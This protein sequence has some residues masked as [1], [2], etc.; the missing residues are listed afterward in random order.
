MSAQNAM[1][2]HELERFL[3]AV[4]TRGPSGQRNLALLTLMADSGL[5][6]G[7]ALGISTTDLVREHGGRVVTH[8]Q[9]QGKGSKPARVPISARTAAR[10]DTWLEARADLGVGNGHVFCTISTGTR[11]A[12]FAQ[13]G[14][15]LVPGK[16][17]D[18]RYVRDL[19]GR[20]ALKA[21]IEG[22]ITPHTL[23]HTFVTHLLRQTGNLELARKAARH[24]R[25]TTTAQVYAHL[26][27]RDVE[28][29]V[30]VLHD[31]GVATVQQQALPEVDGQA[32]AVLEAL[33]GLTPA[34]RR[35]IAAA[36]LAGADGEDEK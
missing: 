5:R 2:E 35:A 28:E 34:Q 1:T 23:R 33:E 24:S 22:H 7:E 13:D 21:G 4:S 19:V 27:D 36:L 17:L 20:V 8:V 32:E 10:L 18:Q 9:V 3:E 14:V 11:Q 29:A 12:G 25:V 26:M 15:E 31:R 16:A 6:V 30:R